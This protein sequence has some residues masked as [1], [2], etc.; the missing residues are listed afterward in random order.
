MAVVAAVHDDDAVV[1]AVRAVVGKN[2]LNAVVASCRV[3]A[4]TVQHLVLMDGSIVGPSAYLQ[5]Q[6]T[7]F[8][9]LP[10][11]S[12]LR[13]HADRAPQQGV[14]IVFQAHVDRVLQK[15]AG[16]VLR[17]HV[18]PEPQKVADIAV[19]IAPCTGPLVKNRNSSNMQAPYKAVEIW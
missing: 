18:D 11:L 10:F 7:Y 9:E 13:A 4:R 6:V 3:P 19:N 14:D 5:Q 1:M 17:A 16:I 12:V 15:A 8:R 2:V